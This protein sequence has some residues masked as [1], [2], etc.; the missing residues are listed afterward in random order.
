MCE[1]NAGQQ[2]FQRPREP[3]TDLVKIAHIH[4]PIRKTGVPYT[5]R[6]DVAFGGETLVEGSKDPETDLARALLA[7]GIVGKVMVM[8]A[9]TM[10]HRTT[11]NIEKAAKLRMVE[12][13]TH[14]R[15]RMAETYAGSPPAGEDDLLP[16]LLCVETMTRL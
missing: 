14:P 3:K 1:R 4:P 5:G 2:I 13:G 15:F 16:T 12:T 9:I 7:R 10:K 6:Y 11:V 8:D